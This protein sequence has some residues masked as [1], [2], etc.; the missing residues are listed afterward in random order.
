MLNPM[1]SPDLLLPGEEL[2]RLPHPLQLPLEANRGQ[3]FIWM[4]ANERRGP[5]LHLH[6]NRIVCHCPPPV[7]RLVADDCRVAVVKPSKDVVVFF[8]PLALLLS[9][10]LIA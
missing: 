8:L 7:S 1:L 6:S 4:L 5:R 10:N 2:L 3:L 9:F